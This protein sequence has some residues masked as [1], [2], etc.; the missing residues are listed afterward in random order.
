[1]ATNIP[2]GSFME[3]GIRTGPLYSGQVP[4]TLI[5]FNPTMDLSYTSYSNSGPGVLLST[6]NTWNITPAPTGNANIVARTNA[7]ADINHM[8][9]TGDNVATKLISQSNTPTY[10]QFDWPRVPT[11]T[12]SGANLNA[13]LRVTIFG[14][15]KYENPLQHT[16]IVQNIGTYPTNVNGLLSVPAKAFFSVTQ[17]SISG[18]L[19]NNAFISVGAADI[20]GLPFVINDAGDITSIG[21]GNSSDLNDNSRALGSPATGVATLVA[22]TVVVPLTAV[23]ANSNI[24]VTRNTPGGALGNLSVPA[25]NIVANTSFTIN[26]DAAGETSTVNWEVINPLGQYTASGFGNQ[27]MV[28]GVVTIFTSQVQANSNIQLTLKTFG[29]A[30]GQWYVSAIVPGVSFTVTSTANTETSTV[31][32]VIMPADLVQGIS[33]NLG[34]GLVPV[35]GEVFVNAP[36]VRANS[37][38]LL[39]YYTNPGISGGILSAPSARI[40]PGIGF[41]IVS[42]NPADSSR[43]IWVI[44]DLIPNLTQGTSTL[45]AGAVTVNTTSVAANSVIL[46][47][48]N[49][50]NAPTPYIRVSAINAG[51]SFTITAQANTDLSSINW[52]IFPAN[53]ILFN[54]VSPLGT[55]VPADQIFPPTAISG[56]VR[57]LYAPSTP[58]NSVNVLRFTAYIQGAD[59][60][61]NQVSNNQFVEVSSNQPVVGT[62]IAPLTPQDL[63]GNPQFYT[64]NNS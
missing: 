16:Y 56:D 8:V 7:I 29:T 10:T 1:M 19:T 62:E 18:A 44:T 23:T 36:S 61:I 14:F 6:Q 33:N 24:Q 47:S 3:D 38:I 13:P 51:V 39:T 64:G 28:A 45:V 37:N 12:I 9:L 49:T 63:V 40:Q 43:V 58:S 4:S 17:V 54:Y 42:S 22:G 41:T 15:D 20:F 11:V 31:S 30:H 46:L 48:D 25:A 32:W 53:F 57:G 35:G 5:P 26:S 55:F 50:L 2:L 52:A 60:W 59:Q 27:A 21:W 34:S